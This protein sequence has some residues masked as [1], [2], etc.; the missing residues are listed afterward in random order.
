M[1]VGIASRIQTMLPAERLVC[2]GHEKEIIRNHQGWS[3]AFRICQGYQHTI[4]GMCCGLTESFMRKVATAYMRIY[5][6]IYIYAVGFSYTSISAG[7]TGFRQIQ[8][9]NT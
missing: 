7:Q 1:H 2:S 9:N 8:V 5:I 4:A 3:P 6:Y